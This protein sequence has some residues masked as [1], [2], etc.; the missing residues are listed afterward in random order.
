[1]S[2]AI[3]WFVSFPLDAVKSN[4]QGVPLKASRQPAVAITRQL[5]A[6]KGILGLYRGVYAS[7]A[8]AFL[9][10]SSRFTAYEFTQ[11]ML[12]ANR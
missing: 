7:V 5:I 6:R 11:Y 2:G 3:G 1:M 8:R 12:I 9:V 4:I 10:S